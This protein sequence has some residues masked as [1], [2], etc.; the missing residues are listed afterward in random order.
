LSANTAVSSPRVAWISG[1]AR[2]IGR[3]TALALAADGCR[4]A[5]NYLRSEE[6]ARRLVEDI[7]AAGGEAEAIQA[8]VSLPE[9]VAEGVRHIENLWGPVGIL[10]CNAGV[11]LAQPLALTSPQEWRAVLAANLDSAFL[12]TKAV[13]RQMIRNRRGRIVYL[14][15]AAARMGDLFHGA[16]SAAKAGLLGLARTAARELAPSGIT[17]NAVAPGPVETEMT[18]G[19]TATR[20]ARQTAAIPMGRFGRPEEVAAVIRFLAS[21]DAAYITGQ[22]FAVDGGLCMRD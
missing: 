13:S 2:G 7:R 8:D 20:R 16:Y 21:D 4:V 6:A 11:N 10:V 5:V 1:A 3:A 19:L 18:A 9:A 14:S 22:V 12:L 15:S 17:V